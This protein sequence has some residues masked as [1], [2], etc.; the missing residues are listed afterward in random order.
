M[1]TISAPVEHKVILSGVSWETYERLLAEHL[2]TSGTHFIYDQ[3]S[4]EIMVLSSR[5]EQPNRILV[6][7]VDVLAVEFGI[8]VI[9]VGSTTFKREELQKGFE[10]DS[11]Y[12][13]AR[14]AQVQGRYVD[15]ADDPP[16][17]LLIEVDI[18]SPS[19]PRFPIY[20]AFGVPEVWRYDGARVAFYRLEGGRY[21]ETASSLAF[22]ALTSEIATRF[23]NER[24]EVPSTQ[25]VRRLQEWA[26]QQG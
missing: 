14:A 22:P 13:I 15:P 20:A 3:G 8:D 19:L 7:M 17:D 1:A 25:W 24:K 9:Q 4:L 12:Y 23:L 5:H 21:G 2:E 6:Q 16:P 18:T 10:P 26:R 11:A